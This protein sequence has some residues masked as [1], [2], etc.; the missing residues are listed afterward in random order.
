MCLWKR[1]H[2]DFLSS[3][4]IHHMGL[5]KFLKAAD[6]VCWFQKGIPHE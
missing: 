2:M 1:L 6:M 5:P 4:P 3:Q